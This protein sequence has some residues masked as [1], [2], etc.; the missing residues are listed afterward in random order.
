MVVWTG[1]GPSNACYS[2]QYDVLTTWASNNIAKYNA[3][4]MKEEDHGKPI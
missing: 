3:T 1:D 4:N 2:W